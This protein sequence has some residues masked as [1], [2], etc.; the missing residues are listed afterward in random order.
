MKR[1]TFLKTHGA[2]LAGILASPLSLLAGGWKEENPL[3]NLASFGLEGVLPDMKGRV[4]YL[5]FWASWCAP[6]KVSFPV[7]DRWQKEFSPKGLT[8]LGVN[9]DESAAE[10][11]AFLNKLPVGFPVVRDAAHKLVAAADVS[12]MPTAF[13]VSR[14]GLIK[15]VHNGFRLKDEAVLATQIQA[16]LQDR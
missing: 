15:H 6:C 14:K 16:L 3:P 10:M 4:L 8:I 11:Q 2:L 7:L 9:V 1:R 5:D 13:L 12:T